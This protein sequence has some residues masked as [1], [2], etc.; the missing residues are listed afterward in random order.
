MDVNLNCTNAA[1]IFRYT[2]LVLQ[3][4]ETRLDLRRSR[5]AFNDFRMFL[6]FFLRYRDE[7]SSGDLFSHRFKMN[8]YIFW[9]GREFKRN[10]GIAIDVFWSS[11]LSVAVM[12]RSILKFSNC[13]F[14]E[15]VLD[16]TEIWRDCYK[17][18]YVNKWE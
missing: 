1:S 7:N 3:C 18:N 2:H 8:Y 14:G 9:C 10:F 15:W 4:T 11:Q 17:K 16:Y 13:S 6:Y 12:D 5:H